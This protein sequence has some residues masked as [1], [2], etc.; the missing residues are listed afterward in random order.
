MLFDG[1]QNL[2]S[3]M[4]TG[5]DKAS[6]SMFVTRT[7]HRE[8]LEAMYRSDWISRKAVDLVPYDMTRA[9]R[10]WQAEDDQIIA[11]ET[12]ERELKLTSRIFRALSLA[13]LYGT[14]IILIG[15]GAADPIT[16]FRPASVRRGGLRYLHVLHRHQF[17]C[18]EINRDPLD[19]QFEE[20]AFYE[21][22]TRAGTTTRIHPSRVIRFTGA[23]LPDLALEPAG[24]GDSILQIIYD[25]ITHAQ[26]A[27][28]NISAMLFEAKLDI[29]KV[30]GL[31]DHLATAEGTSRLQE[32]FALANQMKSIQ[33]MLLLGGDETF[34]QKQLNFQGLPDVLRE[35]LQVVSGAVDIPATRFL[36]QSP[37][38]MN[39]T[40]ECD[41]RNY[42]DMIAAKQEVDLRPAL[43]RLDEALIRHALGGWPL[44]VVYEFEP[45]WQFTAKEQV[46]TEKL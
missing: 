29:I 21:I 23:P 16:P 1:L 28:G 42:Y 44:E 7:L 20:P 19:P 35:Y 22:E 40:G 38:G 18:G 13:R 2:L 26:S 4:M 8:Q 15:D 17:K 46:D 27:A 36:S 12:A 45:L 5:S 33:N 34:E 37:G 6:A 43:E 32:R 14:S 10:T 31:A 3:G 9:G 39:A 30:P 11:I 41:L 24:C 25:A